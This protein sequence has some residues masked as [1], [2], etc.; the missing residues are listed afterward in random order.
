MR[1][2]RWALGLA[3]LAALMAAYSACG[4]AP[5]EV[6]LT[7]RAPMGLLDDATS[8]DLFVFDA[9]GTTCG[10]DGHV[11]A[12]DDAQEFGLDNSGCAEGA[13][14]CGEITLDRDGSTKMFSVVARGP[15]GILG[16]GCATAV[17]DQD[18]VDVSIKI[19]RFNPPACCN[20]GDLQA[21]E[22][23]E[24]PAAA[25]GCD[26]GPAGECAG[27]TA[28]AVCECDCTSKEVPVDRVDPLVVPT[29]GTKL[30]LAMT[31][32][33][34]SALFDDALRAVFVDTEA[35]GGGDIMVRYLQKDLQTTID[36]PAFQAPLP[37]PVTCGGSGTSLARLQ[38]Q[39]D[40]G[41]VGSD[42]VIVYA[43]NLPSPSEVNVFAQHQDG[44]GCTPQIQTDGGLVV[45]EAAGDSSE[46]AVAGGPGGNALV[47]WTQGGEVRGRS[48][49]PPVA[50]G[51]DPTLGTEFTIGSGSHPRV[52]G[53]SNGWKVVYQ[54]NG[55][56]DADGIFMKDVSS[57]FSVG[58]EVGV[59]ASTGGLQDQPDVAAFDD[60]RTA[61]VWRSDTDIYIQRYAADGSPVAGD[62]DEPLNTTREGDQAAPA[63]AAAIGFG[64]FYAVAWQFTARGEIWGRLAG[65]TEGFEFNSVTGQNDDFL[66]SRPDVP[67]VRTGA[68]VAI[69]GGG[70]IAIGWQDESSEHAGVYVRRFPLPPQ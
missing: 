29:A 13:T 30:D 18:P 19:V 9:S 42:T 69:G 40:I 23:C 38:N 44:N 20:D 34:G 61:V 48:W 49:T 24:G 36:P 16:E 21:G 57:S 11:D 56:G 5:V 1:T 60:G 45:S 3:P 54:G 52:A 53:T 64:D 2:R 58:S 68:A 37:A 41:T 6:A 70:F 7:M 14:W 33:P 62:Q 10:D 59:N 28:D 43:S 4:D 55:S 32:A 50:S 47:V 22:Q 39:P 27:I 46:P 17:I 31:F 63:I 15:S 12:P 66:A 35:T 67:G 26:G 65:A 25:A 8:V 51:S